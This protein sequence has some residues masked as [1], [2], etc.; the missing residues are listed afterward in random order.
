VHF[1]LSSWLWGGRVGKWLNRRKEKG[2]NKV[3]AC[4][5]TDAKDPAF[6]KKPRLTDNDARFHGVFRYRI[7][8]CGIFRYRCGRG[9]AAIAAE[10]RY[11][12]S[13]RVSGLSQLS[14]HPRSPLV[15]ISQ[16]LSLKLAAIILLKVVQTQPYCNHFYQ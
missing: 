6:T 12:V 7:Q 2:R 14:V 5:R 9:H 11:P 3:V 16:L 10:A 4:G 15:L 8:G 13:G 1:R